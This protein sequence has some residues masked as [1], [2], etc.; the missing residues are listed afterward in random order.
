MPREQGRGFLKIL[1]TRKNGESRTLFRMIGRR[2]QPVQSTFSTPDES[3]TTQTQAAHLSGQMSEAIRDSER[4]IPEV[5]QQTDR[6]IDQLGL[7]ESAP[8]EETWATVYSIAE[9]VHNYS[10]VHSGHMPGIKY[11]NV[12][13]NNKRLL[14]EC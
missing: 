10:S 8:L 11:L 13:D 5:V 2:G 4:F 7:P 1:T 12:W 14:C 6:I 3:K 9:Y